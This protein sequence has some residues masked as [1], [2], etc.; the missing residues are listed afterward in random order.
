MGLC[1]CVGVRIQAHVLSAAQG[2]CG[3]GVSGYHWAFSL[4]A[5]P[6]ALRRTCGF[7]VGVSPVSAD[8]FLGVYVGV[9]KEELTSK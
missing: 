6:R 9:L 7:P 4:S 2:I 3:C 1:V 8:G 5:C